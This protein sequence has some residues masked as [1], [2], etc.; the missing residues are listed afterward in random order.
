MQ[1]KSI[2]AYFDPSLDGKTSIHFENGTKNLHRAN[3][4]KTLATIFCRVTPYNFELKLLS[5]LHVNIL[6]ARVLRFSIK[7]AER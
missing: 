4:H 3:S 5:F 1:V 7:F 6:A 2:E